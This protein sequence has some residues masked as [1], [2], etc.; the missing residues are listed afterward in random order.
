MQI[1]IVLVLQLLCVKIKMLSLNH[2]SLNGNTI[3][4][5]KY[6]VTIARSRNGLSSELHISFDLQA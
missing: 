4:C 5:Q 1:F 6:I 3:L 2:K